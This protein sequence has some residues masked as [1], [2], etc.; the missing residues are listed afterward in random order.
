M[1]TVY[2]RLVFETRFSS[3]IDLLIV[4]LFVSI[5]TNKCSLIPPPYSSFL[6][7]FESKNTKRGFEPDKIDLMHK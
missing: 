6:I 4:V 7:R 1:F 2:L 5:C 3:Y